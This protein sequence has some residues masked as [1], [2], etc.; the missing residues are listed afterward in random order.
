MSWTKLQFITAAFEEI[1]IASYDFDLNPGDLE[2]AMRR[3]DAMIASWNATGIRLGYPLPSSPENSDLNAET[4]VQDF[5]NEAILLNL[6]IRV[7]PGFGKTVSPD[8]KT[9][10]DK[11]YQA[12]LIHHTQPGIKQLPGMMPLGA[13][14][15]RYEENRFT[16]EPEEPIDVGPDGELE[17]D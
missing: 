12:L 2:S 4:G 9:N 3:L 14:N 1:G 10:A 15:K 16:P 5:A 11:S 6:A 13:G 7:A 8:T 17:F